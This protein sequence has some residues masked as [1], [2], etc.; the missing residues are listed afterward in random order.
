MPLVICM[1]AC[2][3]AADLACQPLQLTP[4]PTFAETIAH[5]ST[6]HP[7]QPLSMGRGMGSYAADWGVCWPLGA[8]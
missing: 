5:G 8:S 3:S 2:A 4:F 7:R 6:G 1:H